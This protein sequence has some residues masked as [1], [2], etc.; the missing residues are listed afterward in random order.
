MPVIKCFN[1]QCEYYDPDEVDNC[2]RPCNPITKCLYAILGKIEKKSVGFYADGL[3]SNECACGH[4]KKRGQ[5][6]CYNCYK[7]LPQDMQ[8]GLYKRIGQGYEEEYEEAVK[9]LEVNVW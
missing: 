5:S 9:W 7:A 2:G 1:S 8:G 6:F 4:T 3:Q